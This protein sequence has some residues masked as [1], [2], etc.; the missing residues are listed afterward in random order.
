MPPVTMADTAIADTPSSRPK[1][2]PNA[3]PA[4]TTRKK[5]P[6]PPPGRSIS[7]SSPA[8]AASMPSSAIVAP[9]I[10]PRRTSSITAATTSAPTSAAMS[11]ASPL[12][13]WL[14]SAVAGQPER[15]EER[16]GAHRDH[17]EVDDERSDAACADRRGGGDDGRAHRRA[18]SG[19]DF[20][21]GEERREHPQHLGREQRTRQHVAGVAV[22]DD[23]A[24]AEHDRVRGAA[25][26]ELDVVG[27]EHDRATRRG[28]LVHGAFQ[29]GARRGVHAARRLVE[30]QHRRAADGDRRDRDPLAFAAREAARVSVGELGEPQRVEPRVDRRRG[31][32][33]RAAAA[34]LR[35]P[36][37]RSARTTSCSGS[38]ARTR[39]A[40]CARTV[41][42]DGGSRPDS[43]RSSVVLP[44][45]LRPN[46]ATT[47]P[48]RTSR[49]TSRTTRATAEHD[50][51]PAGRDAASSPGRAAASDRRRHAARSS[52]SRSACGTR[53]A[54]G[55]GQ[56][57]PSEQAPEAGDGR[58]TG[59]GREDARPAC[60]GRRRARRST[61]TARSASGAA[62]S[63]RC[64]ATT[65]VV[66]RSALRRVSAASTSSAPCG[67]SCD[68]GS[69][70]TRA[71]GAAASAPAITQRCRSP[72]D[73]VAGV[74]VAEVGD[75]ERVEG[76][77]DPAAHRLLGE[78]EV[79]EHE[80]EVA[81]DVVDD[82]LRLR[83]LA[84]E[85][86]RRRRARGGWW[87]RVERPN[88]TTS[89]PNRP[90]LAWGTRPLIAAQQRALARARTRPRP[91]A[92]R[93]A[94][95]RGRR[96]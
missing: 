2:G 17:Q 23:L 88:T 67:S 50:A 21:D 58:R 90:P 22:G 80:R 43:A 76:L 5:I 42:V 19:F 10:V 9:F 41:P 60:R 87:L 11:G 32:R 73:S 24:V 82:E 12:C 39:R 81:F 8:H 48:A 4:S 68:V 95:R 33:G 15:V 1:R 54:D 96:R 29:R 63:S 78:A 35:A 52:G 77:L 47:S 65:T 16:A 91:G 38:A 69:S 83:V 70:S 86:R 6:L 25:R 66:P 57:V 45:P 92:P 40:R 74:A 3:A 44:E 84:H 61:S 26:R 46:S 27:G 71:D 93:R 13:A 72:P 18:S 75:A 56:R 34:S 31:R 89:P 20:L 94:R 55:E 7:R 51:E 14:V 79:L 59:V 37:A 85:A 30:Q 64:S 49:S 36:G 28:V 62:R 53:V